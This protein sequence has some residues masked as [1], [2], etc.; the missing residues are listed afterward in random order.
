LV[1][2]A[3]VPIRWFEINHSK[4]IIWTTAPPCLKFRQGA[5]ESDAARLAQF[6]ISD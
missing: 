2:P 1:A 5:L 6:C 3:A 4:S